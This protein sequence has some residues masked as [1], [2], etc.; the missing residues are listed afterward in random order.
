MRQAHI[1]LTHD[2]KSDWKHRVHRLRRDMLRQWAERVLVESKI[3]DIGVVIPEIMAQDLEKG[4]G[5]LVSWS[6]EYWSTS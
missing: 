6:R 4:Q 1:W 2:E 5:A 3:I